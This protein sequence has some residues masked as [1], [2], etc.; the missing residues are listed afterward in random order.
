MNRGLE[1]YKILRFIKREGQPYF[2]TGYGTNEFKEST[3][4]L[5]PIKILGVYHETQGYV[6]ENGT[7]GSTI[8]GKPRSLLMCSMEDSKRLSR[9]MTVE[10]DKKVY[11]IVDLRNVNNLNLVCDISLELVLS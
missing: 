1:I 5:P 11:K 7:N 8:K 6:S 9:G 4:P 2:F 3:V 10:I